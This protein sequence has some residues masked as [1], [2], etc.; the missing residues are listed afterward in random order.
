MFAGLYH[1]RRYEFDTF[2]I[3][4]W[5]E[6][7]SLAVSTLMPAKTQLLPSC[8]GSRRTLT[9]EGTYQILKDFSFAKTRKA[10]LTVAF[11]EENVVPLLQS[12]GAIDGRRQG[13]TRLGPQL[14]FW[15][16]P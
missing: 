9:L 10:N 1:G 3:T 8:P 13:S 6:T 16:G 5:C 15:E 4:R 7:P 2:E 11:T 14:V 12:L